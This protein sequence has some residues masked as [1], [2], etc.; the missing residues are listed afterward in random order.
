MAQWVK[1]PAVSLLWHELDPWPG[2]FWVLQVQLKNKNKN[3]VPCVCTIY[4]KVDGKEEKGG[5]KSK[6]RC[7]QQEPARQTD[8]NKTG[9]QGETGTMAKRLRQAD[10]VRTQKDTKKKNGNRG[11][12]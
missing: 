4:L 2:N 10:C 11:K 9:K 7:G 8:S 3:I 5:K 6:Q 12:Q 1:D